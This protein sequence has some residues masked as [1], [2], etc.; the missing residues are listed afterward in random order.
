MSPE[1]FCYWLR[2]LFEVGRPEQLNASQTAEIKE[3]LDK[4]FRE[5]SP[6]APGPQSVSG[7]CDCHKLFC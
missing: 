2:G 4:V 6:A 1:Q 3:H 7:H 5:T